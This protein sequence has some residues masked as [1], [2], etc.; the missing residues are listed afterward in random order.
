M[1]ENEQSETESG[2]PLAALAL[3][4]SKQ[5]WT[6]LSMNEDDLK[7]FATP[8]LDVLVERATALLLVRIVA[9][10]AKPGSFPDLSTTMICM[11]YIKKNK[12]SWPKQITTEVIQQ[13]REFVYKMLSG[14][15]EVPYHN[16]E[17]A[18]HV[19]LSVNKML[20][21]MACTVKG[22]KDPRKF[23]PPP[24]FGLRNDPLAMFALVFA[25]LIHDVEHQGL[26]NRQLASENDRLAVLY[27]DQ[28]IA[29]NWSLYIAFS[30]LL[31]D[32]FIDLRKCMFGQDEESPEYVAQYQ[33]FRKMVVSLVLHTDLASPERTQ[34]GKSKWKE[35][36]GDSHETVEAKLK[37]HIRRRS[38]V[39]NHSQESDELPA[40]TSFE[41][42]KST[43]M[44]TSFAEETARSNGLFTSSRSKVNPDDPFYSEASLNGLRQEGSNHAAG[45]RPD[46]FE[47][48]M[49]G[50]HEDST[51]GTPDIDWQEFDVTEVEG[52]EVEGFDGTAH[53]RDNSIIGSVATAP[54]TE[55]ERVR[56]EP[57]SPQKTPG[58]GP[59][60]QSLYVQSMHTTS[61]SHIDFLER[62][63]SLSTSM[64]RGISGGKNSL[65]SFL[66][67][68][69]HRVESR[70]TRDGDKGRY[71]QRLGILR[72]LDLGGQTFET[73]NRKDKMSSNASVAFSVADADADEPDELKM[74]V[75]ME[76]IMSAAD[77]AHNLQSW[78]HMLT[79]SRRLYFE[80]Q[81]AHAAGRG[82]DVAPN[83]YEN[84]IG[85]LESYILP[86]ARKLEDTGVWG[87]ET[88]EPSI[89]FAQN[90]ENIRDEWFEKG[91]EFTEELVAQGKAIFAKKSESS[92]TK[93]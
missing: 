58:G 40:A 3:A 91:S 56:G 30:E 35:A 44:T 89:L 48:V 70:M 6:N 90:V 26:P 74:T 78:N 63:S 57:L 60:Q 64:S 51:T 46:M 76:T 93:S 1:G 43:D 17:H 28:S 25:A 39:S 79:W 72:T 65:N 62:P 41:D 16:R 75:V 22:G 27:N 61:A 82:V 68:S 13:L 87:D 24:S 80:L 2:P 85:F 83:W 14:Y 9:C 20:D 49:E 37:K 66:N 5:K 23:R 71:R 81:R 19:I 53:T 7:T 42:A 45:Q 54:P 18:Y 67:R 8:N 73:Y 12:S 52:T 84:Q 32:E 69:A 59:P 86:L 10:K 11:T 92:P 47:S 36:F 88:T 50:E 38:T 29:E 15:K 55:G 4:L 21:M 34:V 77:V 33:R 31:Q